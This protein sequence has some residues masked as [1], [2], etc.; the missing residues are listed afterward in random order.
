MSDS[1]LSFFLK[2]ISDKV[3]E[4]GQKVIPINPAYTSQTCSRCDKRNPIKQ[5]LKDR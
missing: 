2:R 1:A 4:T 5:E 3:A